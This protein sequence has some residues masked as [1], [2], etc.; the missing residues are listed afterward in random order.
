MNELISKIID[1]LAKH[2]SLIADYFADEQCGE[3]STTLY[4]TDR[5]VFTFVHISNDI[6]LPQTL[7]N[8]VAIIV[9]QF[10]NERK[11]RLKQKR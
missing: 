10:E 4:I 8:V 6:I 2:H 3:D 7:D 11:S 9:R 1:Q 5:E